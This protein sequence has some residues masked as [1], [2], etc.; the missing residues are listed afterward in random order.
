M[1]DDKIQSYVQYHA[2]VRGGAPVLR[3]TR[4][5]IAQVFAELA[6]G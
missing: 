2:S 4:F 3:G 5:T 6:D 1:S